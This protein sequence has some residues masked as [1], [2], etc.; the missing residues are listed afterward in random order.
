MKLVK[1]T[2]MATVATVAIF[3]AAPAFAVVTPCQSGEVCG[4]DLNVGIN[5]DKTIGGLG[6]I[7]LSHVEVIGTG[8]VTVNTPNPVANAFEFSQQNNGDVSSVLNYRGDWI[9]G[10]FV[11]KVSAI[12]N[13]ASVST[14]GSTAIESVQDN[15]GDV[16]ASSDISMAHLVAI[17]GVDVSVTAVGNNASVTTTGDLVADTLQNNQGN[18]TATSDLTL[19]GQSALTT[20]NI[21][22]DVTA[23][24]NNFS[25]KDN[26]A[27]IGSVAQANCGDVTAVGN[28]SVNGFYDPINVTAIGNNLS[29]SKN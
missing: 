12:A 21:N 25:A 15:N 18:V 1:Q 10:N 5:T 9:A 6:G 16:T 28:V 29:I 26:G 23:I 3:S 8:P 7:D 11:S 4:L 13:N 27:L 2:L 24:G 22:L 17:K 20:A 14:V 19:M